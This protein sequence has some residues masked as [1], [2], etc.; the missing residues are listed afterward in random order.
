MINILTLKRG[1]KYSSSTVNTLFS[2]I[3]KHSTVPFRF[4][5]YTDNPDNL[6]KEI[7][8]EVLKNPEEFPAHW[9]KL[10][11]HQPGFANIDTG[12]DI[13]ILD[14]DL[15]ILQNIDDILNFPVSE[16]EFATIERWWTIRQNWCPING[17][18]QKFKSGSTNHFWKKFSSMSEYWPTFF[19][20]IG[21]ADPPFMGE[22]N[23]IHHSIEEAGLARK[24]FPIDWF[25]KY[26]PDQF[27]LQELWEKNV[28]KTKYFYR[29][30]FDPSIKIVHF[31]NAGGKDNFVDP[32]RDKWVNKF[33]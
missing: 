33:L 30:D 2:S 17:G 13:L 24:Y 12:E 4:I 9:H 7:N 22:Q 11:F 15:V 32:N 19:P 27:E 20:S 25:A 21:Q 26:N 16:K 18:V 23:F 31:S 8:I 5:C 10:K 3:K 14:I 28:R 6:D 1:E 29:E